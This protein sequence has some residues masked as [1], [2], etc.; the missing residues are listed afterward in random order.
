MR[1]P[2]FKPGPL[3]WALCAC[4]FLLPLAAGASGAA[5]PSLAVDFDGDGRHDTVRLDRHRPSVLRIWL[6][7][8]DTTQVLVSRRPLSHVAATDLDGD[9]RPELIASDSQSRLHIW[10]PRARGFRRYQPRHSIPKALTSPTRPRVDGR[11]REPEEVLTGVAFG[12]PALSRTEHL[13]PPAGA[14]RVC[15]PRREVTCPASPAARPFSPRPP[16]A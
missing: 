12:P 16:P 11:N 2:A 3:L 14:S 9:H 1:H 4:L 10:T 7:A 5:E 15:V 8:S 13:A 6:S